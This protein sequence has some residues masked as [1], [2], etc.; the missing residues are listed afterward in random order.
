[1]RVRQIRAVELSPVQIG[2]AHHGEAQVGAAEIST[3]QV[4]AG[5]VRLE[6]HAVIG[7]DEGRQVG[8]GQIGVRKIGP[9]EVDTVERQTR[10]IH[11]AQGGAV[12]VGRT[13][14][15]RLEGGSALTE[16]AV[17]GG[18]GQIGA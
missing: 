16:R 6:V 7:I 3:G 14:G 2:A 9:D 4:G 8:V 5:Q 10:Q 17:Q 1:V 15:R 12:E 18:P 11:S 13:A